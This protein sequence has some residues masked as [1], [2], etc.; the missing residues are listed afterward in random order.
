[1]LKR[2][3]VPAAIALFLGACGDAPTEPVTIEPVFA[4]AN[5][6]PW[7]EMVNGGGTNDGGSFTEWIS[8]SVRKNASGAVSGNMEYANLGF[9]DWRYHLEPDCL[10]VSADGSRA[11]AIGARTLSQGP[12]APPL[13]TRVAFLIHDNG[14]G[15]NVD[16]ART[17]FAGPDEGGGAA[18]ENLCMIRARAAFTSQIG[19]ESTT[20]SIAGHPRSAS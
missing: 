18:L 8:L 14:S 19:E 4:Q 10:A 17:F 20:S 11:V 15:E 6:G 12:D 16:R 1:M 5:G 2:I 9:Q 7:V 13:G 3:V